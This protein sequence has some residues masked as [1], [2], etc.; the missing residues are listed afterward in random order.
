[1]SGGYEA[2]CWCCALA[3]R[4]I[5][6]SMALHGDVPNIDNI[7]TDACAGPLRPAVD[8]LR[9]N[10]FNLSPVLCMLLPLAEPWPSQ[11]DRSAYDLIN[12]MY[13][14]V[15]NIWF[16]IL[17]VTKL[18]LRLVKLKGQETVLVS[19]TGANSSCSNWIRSL[20]FDPPLCFPY[21]LCPPLWA[22]IST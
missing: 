11:T 16:I 22:T 8:S 4:N 9:Q 10:Q 12:P 20:K 3:L 15:S 7:S 14:I 6:P 13:T 18:L 1:V 2:A 21:M 17:L 19:S 5:S